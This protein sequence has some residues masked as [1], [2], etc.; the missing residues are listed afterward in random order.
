MFVDYLAPLVEAVSNF[1]CLLPY[2]RGDLV[3]ESP[4][5]KAIVGVCVVRTRGPSP[6]LFSPTPP[7]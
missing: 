2:A 4:R 6:P 3:F 1:R 7:T 5:L